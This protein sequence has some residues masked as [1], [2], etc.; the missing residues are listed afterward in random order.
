[1]YKLKLDLLNPLN[2]LDKGYSIIKSDNKIIKDVN[3]VNIL[4]KLEIVMKNGK[5]NAVVEGVNNGK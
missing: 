2:I 4:D 1:M 5:I 3:S